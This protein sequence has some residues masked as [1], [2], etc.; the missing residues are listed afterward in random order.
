[1]T[2]PLFTHQAEAI[3]L[4]KQQT[5][6]AL[7]HE[8]GLGKTRTV[9]EIF[10]NYRANVPDL[11]LLVV[12]PKSIIK[13]AWLKNAALWV[14]EFTICNMRKEKRPENYDIMVINYEMFQTEKKYHAIKAMAQLDNFMIALDESSKIKNPK[15]KRTLKLL[16]IAEE[17][18]ARIIMSGTPAPNGEHEYWAQIAF[19]DAQVL[20]PTF[21]EFQ[22]R[23]FY[24]KRGKQEANCGYAPGRMMQEGFKLK[25]KPEKQMLLAERT[26]HLIHRADKKTANL[27]L[28]P[29]VFQNRIVT[30][31]GDE[32]TTYNNM[33]KHMIVQVKDEVITSPNVVAK[34]MKLRQQTSG[35]LYN[36]QHEST[37]YGKSK[38]NEL[39]EVLEE[40]GSQQS[41]I[42]CEF[43]TEIE[44]IKHLYADKCATLYG[45]TEDK[46]VEIESFLSGEKQYLLAHPKSG[47]HGLTFVNC[48]AMIYF[49]NSCS[50][51]NY[52]QS[53]DRNHRA[54]QT[55]DSCLYINLIAEDT[56]D[57]EIIYPALMNKGRVSEL[58]LRKFLRR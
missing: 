50:F 33:K 42:W 28:P 22:N 34:I 6:L 54:G 21:Q 43:Q 57:D 26:G 58:M 38:L 9:L 15:A 56:V 25:I 35:F 3:A 49:N 1:M 48:S 53:Q 44:T 37:W 17:F 14:P 18:P 31:T 41:I 51:E 10:R 46:D 29:K 16:E 36:A 27:E 4:A 30:L 47:G 8:P 19:L 5:T 23:F 11:K 39:A 12:C 2:S 52:S 40:L 32:R 7:F 45:G 13:D 20:P 24:L 55:A